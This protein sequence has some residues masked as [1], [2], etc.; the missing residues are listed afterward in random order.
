MVDLVPRPVEFEIGDRSRRTAYRLATHAHDEAHQRF[1]PRVVAKELVAL[2]VE[3]GA[4]DLDEAGII[5]AALERKLAQ[6]GGVKGVSR[7][8]CR[9]SPRPQ[10]LYGWMIFELHRATVLRDK[11]CS[12][13]SFA[14]AYV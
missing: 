11:R 10:A 4:G 14:R 7:N 2:R 1:G 12:R 6:L 3:A 9:L 8:P 13:S 5:G